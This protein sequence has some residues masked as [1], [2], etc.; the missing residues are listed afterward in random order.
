[1]IAMA[2]TRQLDGRVVEPILRS[3]FP[4]NAHLLWDDALRRYDLV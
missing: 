4:R 2:A 1:L 3:Y